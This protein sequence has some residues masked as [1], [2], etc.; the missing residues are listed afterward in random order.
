MEIDELRKPFDW[1]LLAGVLAAITCIVLR[2]F[3]GC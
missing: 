1:L 3:E 2:W